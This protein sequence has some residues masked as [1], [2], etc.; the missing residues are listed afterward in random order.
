M[1]IFDYKFLFIL[2]IIFVLYFMYQDMNDLIIRMETLEFKLNQHLNDIYNKI[3]L[4]NINS[5]FFNLENKNPI[6]I[7]HDIKQNP[8]DIFSNDTK[9]Q[10]H[11]LNNTYNIQSIKSDEQEEILKD[12]NLSEIN[13]LN[14]SYDEKD[15]IKLKLINL[16][17]IARKFNISINKDTNGKYKTKQELINNI[18]EKNI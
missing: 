12:N 14:N 17:D 1:K 18:L 8:I 4:I 16:Q 9:S 11:S 13:T 3:N 2:I 15:L 5:P 7:K 6:I 10:T